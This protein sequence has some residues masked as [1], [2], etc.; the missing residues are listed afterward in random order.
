MAISKIFAL[1]YV[2]DFPV[3]GGAENRK[4]SVI[5]TEAAYY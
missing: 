2:A 4:K 1:N 5:S 3:A